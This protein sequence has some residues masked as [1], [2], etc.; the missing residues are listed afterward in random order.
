MTE[1]QT[2]AFY[3][4][5][6][7][8]VAEILYGGAKGGGKSFFLCLWVYLWALTIATKYHLP[9]C[10][11]PPHVG[12]MGR[13][14]AVDFTATTLQTWTK[15]IPQQNYIIKSGTEKAPKHILI[16]GRVAVDFG[17]LDKQENISHFN[18]AEYAF[19]A[20]DQAEETSIDD[21]ATLRAS[22]R[23]KLAGKQLK[24]KSLFTANP[25]NCWLKQEFIKAPTAEKRF[26][27]ALP[28]DNPYLPTD[29]VDTLNRAFGHRP[30]LLQAYLYGSWDSLEGA[31]V[32]IKD[33][34]LDQ[35]GKVH[36]S[37]DAKR[38][39]ALDPAEYGDD[40]TCI[41]LLNNT[42]IE[43]TDIWGQ[44]P[45]DV[46]VNRAAVFGKNHGGGIPFV[47]DCDGM[48]IEFA[49]GLRDLGETVIEFWGSAPSSSKSEKYYNQR[50][51]M[52]WGAGEDFAA[53]DI[54]LHNCTP[55]L[56]RQLTSAEYEFRNG[57]IIVEPKTE[58]K[59]RIG[60]SPDH[61]DSY[62][63]GLWARRYAVGKGDP[64]TEDDLRI[65]Q[66]HLLRMTL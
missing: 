4:L 7:P 16:D 12:W 30:E 34:W 64:E 21:V 46:S 60:R 31:K 27:R 15:T 49:R 3:C 20:I 58:I 66:S 41:T 54:E 43:A 9:R 26:V 35:A 17:G 2:E 65:D 36:R 62:L 44:T 56:R 19:I 48:G 37:L 5:N 59:K 6:D 28:A 61:A 47:V 14:Q 23:L 63:M 53:G 29:Y 18:S 39:I 1:R 10:T 22:R 57:R 13:K 51:E 55:E 40:E 33:I 8:G 38:I 24:Y 50:A 25:A 42:D 52:W 11:N 45:R 32:I